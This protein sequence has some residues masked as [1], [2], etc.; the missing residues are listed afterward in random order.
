MLSNENVSLLQWGML[1]NSNVRSKL[2]I[3]LHFTVTKVNYCNTSCKLELF[4][5]KMLQIYSKV[6]NLEKY[7]A[8]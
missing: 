5:H 3:Y 8:Q 2:M 4:Y 6:L 7:T 1:E